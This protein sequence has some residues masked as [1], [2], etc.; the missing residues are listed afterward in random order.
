MQWLAVA[1]AVWPVS[2]I[3]AVLVTLAQWPAVAV[4]D[5]E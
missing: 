1:E 2:V 3:V 5:E 4:T